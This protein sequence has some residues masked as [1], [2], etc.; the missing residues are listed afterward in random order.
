MK[1]VIAA[2]ALASAFLV[3]GNVVAQNDMPKGDTNAAAPA[4]ANKQ[5]AAKPAKATKRKR[6]PRGQVYNK[7]EKKCMAR[8]AKGAPAAPATPAEPATPA[9]PAK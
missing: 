7:K 4:Q 9:A 6:C 1:Q 5:D 8:V 3:A 2:L